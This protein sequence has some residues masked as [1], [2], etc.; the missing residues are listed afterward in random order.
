MYFINKFGS[1]NISFQWKILTFEISVK[2]TFRNLASKFKS[3]KTTTWH[4][5]WNQTKSKQKLTIEPISH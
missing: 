2:L 4:F 3:S 5:Y 1:L